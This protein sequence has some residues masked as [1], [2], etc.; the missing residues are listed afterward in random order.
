MVSIGRP[1][2]MAS[3]PKS[4]KRFLEDGISTQLPKRSRVELTLKQKYDLIVESEKVPKPTQKDLSLKFGIGKTTVSDILKKR[5]N[6]KITLKNNATLDRKQHISGSKFGDLNHL[7][8][9][10]FKQARSKHIPLSGPIIQ[11]KAMCF[12]QELNIDD[13]K[14]SN[15]WLENW[16]ARL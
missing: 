1:L 13:F 14:A 15:G 5:W 12:A 9:K 11:E 3:T 10:W 7:V 16:K 4:K 8:Y 2:N 6:T